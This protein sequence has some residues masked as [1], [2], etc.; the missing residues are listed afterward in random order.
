[1]VKN[2]QAPHLVYAKQPTITNK[3]PFKTEKLESQVGDVV[4][5]FLKKYVSRVINAIKSEKDN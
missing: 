4:E 3:D 2:K 1:M 5:K